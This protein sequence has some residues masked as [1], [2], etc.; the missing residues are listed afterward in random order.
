MKT[1]I[2]TANDE[3]SAR[4]LLGRWKK[5][6]PKAVIKKETI[7]LNPNKAI[8]RYAA[9]SKPTVTIRIEYE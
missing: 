2:F 9:P 7:D 3:L 8:G 1:E 6:N 4:L 5:A